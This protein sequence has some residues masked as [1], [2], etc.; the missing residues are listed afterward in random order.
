MSSRPGL[1]TVATAGE[2]LG[3][4]SVERRTALRERLEPLYLS[5]GLTSHD[6]GLATLAGAEPLRLPG[7]TPELVESALG[8]TGLDDYLLDLDADPLQRVAEWLSRTAKFR[9]VGGDYDPDTD[10]GH[11]MTRGSPRDR[12][13]H[14][15][16][17]LTAAFVS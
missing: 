3:R 6:G 5:I 17:N 2:R 13:L 14:T 8:T 16:R 4:A 15:S 10:D 1:E 11:H 9:V 7:A 12:Y